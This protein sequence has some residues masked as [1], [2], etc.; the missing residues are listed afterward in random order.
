MNHRN[1]RPR[2]AEN[3]LLTLRV[4]PEE[5]ARLR[6]KADVIGV[7]LSEYA[8][9]KIFGGR[10]IIPRTDEWTIRELRRMGGLLKHHF[11]TL[12]E[13]N[14]SEDFLRQIGRAHV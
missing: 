9:A 11:L 2:Y 5:K 12:R 6:E 8:R 13:A 4:T 7:S 3:Q 1:A 14:V 10:P